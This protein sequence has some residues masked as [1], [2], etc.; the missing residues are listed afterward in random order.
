[1]K[2]LHF[3]NN[4]DLSVCHTEDRHLATSGYPVTKAFWNHMI[5]M[6][7]GKK[8]ELKI[9]NKELRSLTKTE[10]QY[11]ILESTDSYGA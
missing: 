7:R 2:G 5:E 1:M 10:N 11:N 9:Q 3:L 4:Q 8:S 6:I